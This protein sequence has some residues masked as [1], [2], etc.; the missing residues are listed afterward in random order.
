MHSLKVNRRTVRCK[1]YALAVAEE[2][3]ED[4]EESVLCFRCTHPLL[5]IIHD[6]HVYG[7]VEADEIV[8]R[9]FQYCIGVLHLEKTRRNI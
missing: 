8:E 6:E 7:L 1:Y 3:V 5:D 2:M 4:V 9:V